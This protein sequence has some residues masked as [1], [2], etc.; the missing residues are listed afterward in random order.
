[1]SRRPSRRLA[2]IDPNQAGI[3]EALRRAGA[4]VWPIQ[5][6][7]DLLVV[8]RGAVHVLEVKTVDGELDAGQK[9]MARQM[10]EAGYWPIVVRSVEEALAAVGAA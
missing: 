1:M 9:E 10:A 2:R 7:F 8:F 4:R 5:W 6:P 3:V